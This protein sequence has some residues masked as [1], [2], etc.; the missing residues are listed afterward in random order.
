MYAS[1][2]VGIHLLGYITLK[3]LRAK[4]CRIHYLALYHHRRFSVIRSSVGCIGSM[5][6]EILGLVTIPSTLGSH[7]VENLAVLDIEGHHRERP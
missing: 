5:E 6:S 1:R 4:W 2:E 7:I 3:A